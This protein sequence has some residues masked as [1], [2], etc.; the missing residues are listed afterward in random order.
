MAIRNPCAWTCKTQISL[1]IFTPIAA[2]GEANH[3]DWH[4]R[5]KTRGDAVTR[6]VG[7]PRAEE[8][9]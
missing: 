9:E 2:E 7:S 8:L 5:S 6:I 4:L 1:D 3:I